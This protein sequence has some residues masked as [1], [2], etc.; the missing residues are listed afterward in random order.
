MSLSVWN[1]TLQSYE[2]KSISAGVRIGLGVDPVDASNPSNLDLKIYTPEG[3]ILT[4]AFSPSRYANRIDTSSSPSVPIT[5]TGTYTFKITNNASWDWNGFLTANLQFQ[6][7]EKPYFYW[8]IFGFA[9]AL[10]YIALVT[11][12]VYKTR[13]LV[14]KK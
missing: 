12:A 14:E 9:I 2:T 8:G 13:H 11:A 4:E 10:G 3:T 7:F 5:Q 6:H 1:E